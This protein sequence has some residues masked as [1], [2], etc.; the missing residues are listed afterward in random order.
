MRNE[1]VKL[2]IWS[3]DQFYRLKH[4]RSL[5]CSVEK[6]LSFDCP[7]GCSGNISC[8]LT[9]KRYQLPVHWCQWSFATF[10]T[11]CARPPIIIAWLM[12]IVKMGQGACKFSFCLERT[13]IQWLY[14]TMTVSWCYYLTYRTKCH[15][16]SADAHL[17]DLA[18]SVSLS[19]WPIEA[20]STVLMYK[21]DQVTLQLPELKDQIW[22][23]LHWCSVFGDSSSVG[24]GGFVLHS[25]QY[26]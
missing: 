20:A 18:G 8:L 17:Q 14:I 7:G 12:F 16:R 10:I 24:P 26:L 15:W 1:A 5:S 25:G 4:F 9:Y 23:T 6:E 2:D 11:Q 19:S 3:V 13:P 21:N 22:L